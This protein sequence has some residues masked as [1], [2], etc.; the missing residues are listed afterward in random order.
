MYALPILHG[1]MTCSEVHSIRIYPVSIGRTGASYCKT[2]EKE[3]KNLQTNSEAYVSSFV[4][5]K[6]EKILS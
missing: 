2:K 1:L 5:S 6:G 3:K 4:L